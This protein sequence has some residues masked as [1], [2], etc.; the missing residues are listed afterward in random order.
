MQH[1]RSYREYNSFMKVLHA[2]EI[3]KLENDYSYHFLLNQVTSV[4]KQSVSCLTSIFPAN[5]KLPKY[6]IAFSQGEYNEFMELLFVTN[7]A[8]QTENRKQL[9]IINHFP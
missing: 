1:K 3:Y 6:K 9:S 5:E 7:L 2:T 4:K 8:M